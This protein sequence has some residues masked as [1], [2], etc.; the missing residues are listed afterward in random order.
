MA[1]PARP[2]GLSS[3]EVALLRA[4]HRPREPSLVAR[5]LGVL[6]GPPALMLV[7]SG[8]FD[9]LGW[10]QTGSGLL[11]LAA[12]VLLA[13]WSAGVAA[14]ALAAPARQATAMRDGRAQ[15][16]AVEDLVRGDLLVLAPGDILSADLSIVD[17]Q[18]LVL[19]GG[20]V[21][22]A[23]VLAG[24]GLGRVRALPTSQ[25]LVD[26]L[27]A[28]LRL[29]A[30]A[31]ALTAVLLTALLSLRAPGEWPHWL[32]LGAV[33]LAAVCA[34]RPATVTALARTAAARRMATAGAVVRDPLAVDALARLSVLCLDGDGL[35]C[36]GTPKLSAVIPAPGHE[37]TGLWLAVLRVLGAEEEG[38][39]EHAVLRTAA[40]AVEQTLPPVGFLLHRR[41]ADYGQIAAHRLGRAT[42]V[43]VLGDPDAMLPHCAPDER[44]ALAVAE[45]T[46]GGHRVLVLAQARSQS[47]VDIEGEGPPPGLEVVGLLGITNPARPAWP[48]A[49]LRRSGVRVVPVGAASA[50]VDLVATH[51]AAGEVVAVVSDRLTFAR[52]LLAADLGIATGGRAA[53]VLVPGDR[54]GALP[55]AIR[56]SRRA[57]RNRHAALSYLAAAGLGLLLTVLGATLLLPA[58]PV[59]PVHLAWLALAAGVLPATA[60]AVDHPPG[61]PLYQAPQRFRLLPALPDAILLAALSLLCATLGDPADARTRLVLALL[62]GQLA[63]ALVCRGE[64][65]PL[66]SGWTGARRTPLLLVGTLGVSLALTAVP[67][68]R[69]AVGLTWIGLDGLGLVLLTGLLAL[70]GTAL[71][72]RLR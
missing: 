71:T 67:V 37:L 8:L 24:S 31:A 23:V 61:D 33:L 69:T 55:A 26:P 58:P 63:L 28:A 43:T 46:K 42:V 59:H 11:T 4:G 65:W 27:P 19:D 41:Q 14:H 50:A 47:T 36:A 54:P 62:A 13:G 32:V 72:R 57:A 15:P 12:A 45:L 5:F 16:V 1:D 25:T 51:R 40:G 20:P 17:D 56:H 49:E 44:F 7:L 70:A 9:L 22:G 3:A 66:E 52:A 38:P 30:V 6:C 39:A 35:A 48:T 21:A 2:A 34:V 60:L 64:R 53:N 10:R 68:L 29:L 18:G